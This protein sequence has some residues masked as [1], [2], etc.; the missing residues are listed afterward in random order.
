M[1]K[2]RVEVK[3]GPGCLVIL[4]ALGAGILYIALHFLSKVW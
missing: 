1:T 2:R 3:V 4:L